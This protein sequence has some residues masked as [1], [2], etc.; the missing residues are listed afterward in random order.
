M[1]EN[2]HTPSDLPT[3][4][5]YLAARIQQFTAMNSDEVRAACFCSWVRSHLKLGAGQTDLEILQTMAP[6]FFIWCAAWKAK[7]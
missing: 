3:A 7:S 5:D 6:H 2:T 1:T 4:S